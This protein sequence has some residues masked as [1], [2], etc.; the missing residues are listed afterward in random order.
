M[1]QSDEDR[2]RAIRE[3]H[4]V[5]LV[6]IGG[7]G[8]ASAAGLLV[9]AGC[10]VRGSDGEI[11]PPSSDLLQQLD[12]PVESGFDPHN[13]DWKPDLVV[14]GN[15]CKKDHPEYQAALD[16]GLTVVSLPELLGVRFIGDRHAIVVAGTHGKT[17][18]TAL[19]AALLKGGDLDPGYMLGG[20]PLDSGRP[21]E[22]GSA[23]YFVVEGDEYGSACFDRRPKFLHYRPRTAVLTGI[24]FDHADVFSDIEAVEQ[25]F[26][27]LVDL[28]PADGLLVVAGDSSRAV[29]LA[30]RARCPVHTYAVS[31]ADDADIATTRRVSMPLDWHGSYSPMGGGLQRLTVQRKDE[32]LGSFVVPL[33]G[34]HNMANALAAVAVAFSRGVSSEAIGRALRRFRGVARRQQVRGV[35]RGVTV[36][37]DFAHHP[38]AVGV[39]LRGLR[40]VHGDGRLVAV[41]E[42]RSATSRRAIFQ[43]E[44]ALALGEADRV[45]VA[46]V[47]RAETVPDGQRLDADRLVADLADEG[48]EAELLAVDEI[49]EAVARD[50]RSG[51]TV[52]VMSSGGF[53]GVHDKLLAALRGD[54]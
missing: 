30:R 29:R 12:I 2:A 7:I 42:P 31:A 40:G 52:V 3:A 34:A 47:F 16:A 18:T 6:A 23:P 28:L 45:V 21:F 35:E 10:D 1:T 22:R 24:E 39:T 36:I 38:T 26:G 54:G 32:Q 27:A 25:A 19:I 46:P 51:D 15:T 4:R 11:Y 9:A 41:F 33:T 50:A 17:S 43:R 49:P 8:M 37:D 14:L 53:G 20:I 48:T 13:L 44:Y 5:H